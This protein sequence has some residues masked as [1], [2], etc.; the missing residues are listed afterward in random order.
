MVSHEFG[1]DIEANVVVAHVHDPQ[2]QP[3]MNE[4]YVCKREDMIEMGHERVLTPQAMLVAKQNARRQG[5]RA[6]FVNYCPAVATE[7]LGHR[8]GAWQELPNW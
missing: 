8:L 3:M 6:E 5:R 1:R 4:L 2:D 7:R